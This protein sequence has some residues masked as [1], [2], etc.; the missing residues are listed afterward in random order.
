MT[1]LWKSVWQFNCPNKVKNFIWRAC[2]GIL[3]TKTK[4]KDRKIPMEVDCDICGEVETVGH[5][6]WGCKLAAA[7][8]KW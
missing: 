6:F 3:P 4:L 8:D 2:K 7:C 1:S 5:V